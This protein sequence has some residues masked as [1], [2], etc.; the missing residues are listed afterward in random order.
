MVAVFTLCTLDAKFSFNEL[1]LK[2]TDCS[3]CSEW[4]NVAGLGLR[5]IWEWSKSEVSNW[6]HLAGPV[7]DHSALHGP[8]LWGEKQLRWN[9]KLY[10]SQWQ[11]QDKRPLARWGCDCTTLIHT[12]KSRAMSNGLWGLQIPWQAL[13][14]SW[15]SPQLAR[16]VECSSSAGWIDV[17][18]FKATHHNFSL[19][20]NRTFPSRLHC[21]SAVCTDPPLLIQHGVWC[22][23]QWSV[24][25]TCFLLPLSLFM[26]PFWTWLR[27]DM[28]FFL[29]NP[30]T[31]TPLKRMFPYTVQI[32]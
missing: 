10:H 14:L 23:M 12:L 31:L 3:E 19:W 30:N 22:N 8:D 17:F 20:G 7:L 29:N 16:Q 1:I 9:Q 28:H 4:V 2:D 11:W 25:N 18:S 6:P 27:S 5:K 15:P 13:S 32:Y 21:V 24:G 26:I